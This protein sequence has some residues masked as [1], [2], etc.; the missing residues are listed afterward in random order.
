MNK[1][2]FN[3]SSSSVFSD[4]ELLTKA[5]ML[6]KKRLPL[7]PYIISPHLICIRISKV[8]P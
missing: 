4:L 7:V 6:K 2:P 3:S 8:A 5:I 1:L